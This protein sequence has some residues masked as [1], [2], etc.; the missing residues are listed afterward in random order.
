MLLNSSATR[1]SLP[2]ASELRSGTARFAT[3]EVD[4]RRGEVRQDGK[5]ISLQEKPLQVLLALL[6]NPGVLVSREELHGRLWPTDTFVGFDEGLNTAV[7]K[8]RHGLN[9]SVDTPQ[10]IET[11]PKRGYRFIAPVEFAPEAA[12]R[13]DPLERADHRRRRRAVLAAAVAILVTALVAGGLLLRTRKGSTSFSSIVVLPLEQLSGDAS[14]EYFADGMTDAITTNLAKIKSLRVISRTSATQFK[15]R[16]PSI[17]QIAEQLGVDVVVEGSVVRS[18]ERVRITAQLIDAHHDRHLWAESFEGGLSDILMLQSTVAASI[19]RQIG[20][21]LS[22]TDH[23]RSDTLRPV[24]PEAYEEYLRG[25][26]YWSKYTV[27]G[28]TNAIP[29]FQA[30]VA[31]DPGYA[32]A[33]VGLA[34][35]YMLLAVYQELPPNDAMPR[36]IAAIERALA[37]DPDLGEAHYS[38]AFARMAYDYDWAGAEKEFRLG[39]DLNPNYAIGRMWHSL[40]LTILGRHDEAIAEL[41]RTRSLDPVSLIINTNLC[42][43]YVYARKPDEA[44]AECKQTLE[45]DPHFPLAYKWLASAYEIKGLHDS[46]FEAEQKARLAYNAP[47]FAEETAQ[48]YR[49]GGRKAK[50]LLVLREALK[51]YKATDLDAT[52][53]AMLYAQLGQ[54]DQA[55]AYLER[56][57]SAREA[58]M[59]L[60]NAEP[61]LDVLHSDARFQKLLQSMN[62][63]H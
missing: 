7:R 2:Q 53:L 41:I 3:F 44:I 60:I 8:L 40:Y 4:I 19:A 36:G 18:G 28:W 17:R 51:E 35:C 10:Y 31:S 61:S 34:D 5:P 29:H 15:G 1:C 6:E 13:T 14:Q 58:S 56:A 46:A 27:D 43:A 12:Q 22:P 24:N 23:A 52:G 55:F 39:L 11:V 38:L 32:A 25:R 9:D 20:A 54:N 30:A 47:D 63:Q 62:L 21:N 57:Y 45:L 16:H 49:L 33:H 37:L 59:A 48:A 26:F 50:L 42:R